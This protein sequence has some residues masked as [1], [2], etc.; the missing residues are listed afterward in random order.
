MYRRY[1]I[2][3]YPIDYSYIESL[4]QNSSLLP[5]NLFRNDLK[6]LRN[7][8]LRKTRIPSSLESVD[9]WTAQ[10]LILAFIDTFRRKIM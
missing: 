10:Q 3:I 4:A 9:A 1:L 5:N 7:N 2:L 8:F 6:S